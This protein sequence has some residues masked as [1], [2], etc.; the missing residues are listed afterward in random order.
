M[1]IEKPKIITGLGNVEDGGLEKKLP[2]VEVK[3]EVVWVNDDVEMPFKFEE[4]K[5]SKIGVFLTT[6]PNDGESVFHVKV[7]DNHFRSALLGKVVFRDKEGNLYR[8]VDIKGMGPINPANLMVESIEAGSSKNV[9]KGKTPWGFMDWGYAETDRDMSEFFIKQGL[10]TH[11]ALAI[12]R[13][14]EVVVE[15]G[16]KMSVSKARKFGYIKYTTEPVIEVRAFGTKARIADSSNKA[17]LEDAKHMVAQEL[18]KDPYS[19]SQEDYVQWF[20]QTLGKQ[21]AIIHNAG[22]IH[23]YL[24]SH[25]ITLDCRIVD[26]DSVKKIKTDKGLNDKQV[27]IDLKMVKESFNLLCFRQNISSDCSKLIGDFFDSYISNLTIKI[28]EEDRRNF[29]DSL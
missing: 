8:D 27:M 28:S 3:N 20:A 2:A 19:F 17:L 21:L 25:N 12:I 10:R 14:D 11:R 5:P 23:G 15:D 4:D 6:E 16:E 26:L 29:N 9:A 24:T 13:L 22:F 1:G 18:G 7:M